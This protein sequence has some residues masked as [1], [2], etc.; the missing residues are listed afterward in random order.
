M[1]DPITQAQADAEQV[2]LVREALALRRESPTRGGAPLVLRSF[3]GGPRP[4]LAEAGERPQWTPPP[5]TH[6]TPPELRVL[7]RRPRRAGGA[8]EDAKPALR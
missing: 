1:T 8:R 5:V 3:P 4:T 7:Y 6:P 2:R